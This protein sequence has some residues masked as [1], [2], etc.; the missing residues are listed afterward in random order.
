MEPCGLDTFARRQVRREFGETFAKLQVCTCGV[1]S[2]PVIEADGEMD[3]GLEEETPRALLVRPD[4]L[5]DFVAAEELLRVEELDGVGERT[6]HRLKVSLCYGR[7]SSLPTPSSY[8]SFS[9][10]AWLIWSRGRVCVT[11]GAK[12]LAW[13]RRRS[14]PWWPS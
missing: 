3:Q 14:I 6:Y 4:F 13:L 9:A 10:N 5:Q 7:I 8:F 11:T 2:L 12:N 1:A